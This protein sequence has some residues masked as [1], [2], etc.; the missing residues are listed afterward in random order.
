[1]LRSAVKGELTSRESPA[2]SGDTWESAE[3]LLRR[4]DAKHQKLKSTGTQRTLFEGAREGEYEAY[5]IPDEPLPSGWAWAAFGQLCEIQLGRA[6]GPGNRSDRYPTKYLRAANITEDGLDLSDM[7]EMEFNPHEREVFRLH[8]GDLLVAE[9]SGSADKVGKPAV[10][11]D[12]LPLCCFQNTVIRLRPN[13]LDSSYVLLLLRHC[14]FNGVFANFSDGMGINHLGAGRL[15]RVIVPLAPEAEQNVMVTEVERQFESIKA[16]K[17]AIDSNLS[18]A[19]ELR[20]AVFSQ[21]F[22][23]EL[24]S[25]G[26][27]VEDAQ[28]ILKQ[29]SDRRKRDI[30]ALPRKVKGQEI[31]RMIASRTRRPLLDVLREHPDGIT[32]EALLAAANY[33]TKDADS[34]Y[35]ELS[36]IAEHVSQEKPLGAAASNWPRSARV[37][38]RLKEV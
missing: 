32:P 23:G 16:S 12:E 9:A 37:I 14:Y 25:P 29:I 19:R 34:F 24:A 10:W 28:E 20:Q 27:A 30:V 13:I 22:R 2:I 31:V 4:I 33:S 15:A 18:R 8:S 1:V 5:S 17:Q 21:A 7:L 26:T 36:R 35:A 38:L 6:K 11:S 3:D